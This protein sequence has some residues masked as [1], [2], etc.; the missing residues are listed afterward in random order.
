[1]T[2][3]ANLHRKRDIYFKLGLSASI[4]LVF[5]YCISATYGFATKICELFIWI[6]KHRKINEF[7]FKLYKSSN[8]DKLERKPHVAIVCPTCNDFMADVMEQNIKQ[9]YKY[10]T[11]FILDDSKDDAEGLEFSRNIDEF[12]KK[13]QSVVDIQIIRRSQEH[14][15]ENSGKVG[16][17]NNFLTITANDSRCEYVA[18]IDADTV[19]R[20]DYIEKNIKL[21]Y[22]NIPR[23]AV[24][25]SQVSAHQINS[26]FSNIIHDRVDNATSYFLLQN[27]LGK[28]CYLGWGGIFKRS[29]LEK[30]KKNGDYFPKNILNDDQGMQ[31]SLTENGYIG[32]FSTLSPISSQEPLNFFEYNKRENR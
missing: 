18:F 7:P 16:N 31:M 23:L 17:L 12:K 20:D 5:I 1:L 10:V 21:F 14:K 13:Y 19:L 24:I 4:I 22:C 27:S 32:F 3:Y 26:K 30:L 29:I 2:N 11:Y 25:T 28:N 6:F 9:K 15:K 8:F